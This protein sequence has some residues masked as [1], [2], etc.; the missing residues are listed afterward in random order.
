MTDISK[1]A[2]EAIAAEFDKR[3]EMHAQL[4][5]GPCGEIRTARGDETAKTHSATADMLRALSARVE[6]LEGRPAHLIGL[7]QGRLQGLDMA[8]AA[9]AKEAERYASHYP[10]GTDG[11][12][13]FTIL[14]DS[15]R[16]H[17]LQSLKEQQS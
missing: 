15:L 5:T 9:G 7:E 2:V 10:E 16:G 17:I 6:E 8:M 12:N 4:A 3:V 11:R 13:T 1:D 14:A